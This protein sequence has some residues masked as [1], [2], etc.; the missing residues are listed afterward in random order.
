LARYQAER[1]RFVTSVCH[2]FV[3]LD[4]PDRELIVQLDGR[5][6]RQS[7]RIEWFARMGLLEG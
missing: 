6:K 3:E 4:D 2:T 1:S 5:R 7:P